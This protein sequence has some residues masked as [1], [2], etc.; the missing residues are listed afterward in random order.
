[1]STLA[2]SVSTS[3][4]LGQ[5][6]Y[7]NFGS[8]SGM[9][10]ATSCS[11][12]VWV[13]PT[14][15][16]AD[17]TVVS[18]AGSALGFAITLD[19]GGVPG[20]QIA[21]GAETVT[22]YPSVDRGPLPLNAWT[23]LALTYDATS[24][25]LSLYVGGLVAAQF[26]VGAPG[27]DA[28]Q[29]YAALLGSPQPLL[30]ISGAS[31]CFQ[32]NI[33]RVAIWSEARSDEQV[34]ADAGQSPVS[35]AVAEPELESYL[36]FT[37]PPT[38]DYSG[39]NT[40]VQYLNGAQFQ[41]AA[42]G[43][44]LGGGGYIDVGGGAQL[45]FSGEVSYTIDGWFYPTGTGTLVSRA[46][47]GATQYLVQLIPAASGGVAVEFVRGAASVVSS[48][49]P[50]N[51]WYQFSAVFNGDSD[52]LLLYINGNLQQALIS[53]S[54]APAAAVDT[55]LG[56]SAASGAPAAYLSGTIQNIR[57][58]NVAL[59]QDVI[60]QWLYNQPLTDATLLGSFDFTV[61]PPVD[62][63]GIN[64]LT[65]E[66]GAAMGT[67]TAA[68]DPSSSAVALGA[69]SSV[70]ASYLNQSDELPLPPPD[71][72]A[73]AGTTALWSDAHRE[74]SWN[75][76]GARLPASIAFRAPSYVRAR[77]SD[78]GYALTEAGPALTLAQ[79]MA[80]R[81]CRFDA[82]F[83]QAH[84]R[85]TAAGRG[86]NV[87]ST[88]MRD[89]LIRLTYHAP[90]GDVLLYEGAS[91]T[92]DAC[93][94]AWVG[95][96]FQLTYGL[97][98]AFG[99]VP[100]LTKLT[101]ADKIAT[102]IYNLVIANPKAVAA[103]LTIVAAGDEFSGQM[104]LNFIY[105]L[106]QQGLLTPILWF[107]VRSAGW[108]GL[109]YIATEVLASVVGA[110]EALLLANVIVWEGQTIYAVTSLGTACAAPSA[111]GEAGALAA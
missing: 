57:F 35:N 14:N 7:V 21:L 76:S 73:V 110:E 37:H 36:D 85:F 92:M 24:G 45:D 80:Q 87:C 27:T 47:S 71:S 104:G 11:I 3:L 65:L 46:T 28:P 66:G 43:V 96:V 109:A 89:G 105:T 50:L 12:E 70:N 9:V 108:W 2:P 29:T 64:P 54:D 106:Y 99:F 97:F 40:V 91:A 48:S 77:R 56:A 101:G 30:N 49:L 74:A 10:G 38:V 84:R 41:I 13:S 61:A 81:R 94:L 32:G 95:V 1:M 44:N 20:A 88:E 75:R 68:L 90:D 4:E 111:R 52:A 17:Q 79:Y 86:G 51:A 62:D 31:I 15:L 26:P 83:A 78:G 19:N 102:R 55:L 67:L 72:G 53:A 60:R 100:P 98:A 69:I 82:G 93:T 8:P 5:Q 22:L 39:M 63:T 25:Q 16:A 103:L 58:W 18:L 34:F 107:C 6:A 42:P 23:Y 33:G 59:E